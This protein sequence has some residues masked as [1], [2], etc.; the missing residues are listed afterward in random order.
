MPAGVQLY[1]LRL[2]RGMFIKDEVDEYLDPSND[3]RLR[4]LL[5]ARVKLVMRT[6]RI[7]L[8]HGWEL[9]VIGV[10]G[11]RVYA[12]VTVDGAGATVIQR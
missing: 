11:S 2:Y 9:W 7:R 1:K 12:K 5:I 3:D 10:N 8:D 4:E 6:N